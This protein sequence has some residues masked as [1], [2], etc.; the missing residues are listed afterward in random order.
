MSIGKEVDTLV[1]ILLLLKILKQ[2]C[3]MVEF[4]IG[5]ILKLVS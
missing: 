5:K 3:M 1:Y 4:Y 2:K